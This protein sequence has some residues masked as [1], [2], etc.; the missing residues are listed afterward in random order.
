MP[1]EECWSAT[2]VEGAR[3]TGRLETV[4]F[5]CSSVVRASGAEVDCSFVSRV[6]R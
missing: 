4:T 2:G 5:L 3:T 6:Y 1:R